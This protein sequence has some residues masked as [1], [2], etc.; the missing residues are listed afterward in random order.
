MSFV[1]TEDQL[2]LQRTARE[3]VSDRMPISLLRRLH[4]TRDATGFSRKA[5]EEMGS[6]GLIGIVLPEEVGGAGLGYAIAP[7][8]AW[9]SSRSDPRRMS[10]AV[11]RAPSRIWSSIHTC[12]FAPSMGSTLVVKTGRWSSLIRGRRPP[13]GGRDRCPSSA[14]AVRRILRRR[15]LITRE[16]ELA[17]RESQVVTPLERL[18]E[19]ARLRPRAWPAPQRLGLL[20]VDVEGVNVSCRPAH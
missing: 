17:P 16:G 9:C 15:G 4:D 11:A 12:T 14:C 19:A 7:S 18:Y 13:R 5:W 8:S 1:L 10:L 2:L 6:L 3:F 20:L